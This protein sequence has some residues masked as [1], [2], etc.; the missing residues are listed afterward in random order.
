MK[1]LLIKTEIEIILGVSSIAL[2][3]GLVI[4]NSITFGTYVSPW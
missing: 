4:Y 3:V 2:I 1:N